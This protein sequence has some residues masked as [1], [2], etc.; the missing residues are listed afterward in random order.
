MIIRFYIFQVFLILLSL[1]YAIADVPDIQL[2]NIKNIKFNNKEID[3]KFSIARGSDDP[4][5]ISLKDIFLQNDNSGLFTESNSD[6]KFH[7]DAKHIQGQFIIPEGNLDFTYPEWKDVPFDQ[8]ERIYRNEI[9]HLIKGISIDQ[10][11]PMERVIEKIEMAN[12][13][14]N[15]SKATHHLYRVYLTTTVINF[16]FINDYPARFY[17]DNFSTYFPFY[18]KDTLLWGSRHSSR[19]FT[20]INLNS[21]IGKNRE[22][23]CSFVTD[24]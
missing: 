9:Y 22:I 5:C 6:N 18:Y 15:D 12:L 11:I 16:L 10:K 19:Y 13:N 1:S 2:Q 4:I 21:K 3:I 23:I 8:L 14:F 17:E 24:N 20:V 7:P